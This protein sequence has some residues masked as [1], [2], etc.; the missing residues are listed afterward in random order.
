M[1]RSTCP[2]S[3]QPLRKQPSA[4]SRRSA[5]SQSRRS[6]SRSGKRRATY[7]GALALLA[8]CS[9][10]ARD[11]AAQSVIKQ[12]G[13]HPA[14][15]FEA[16]PH[17]AVG[18]TRERGLGPGFRGTFELVDNGF[19]RSINNTVGVS[20]GADVLF[21]DAILLPVA[22]QWNFWILREISVFGEVGPA[23]VIDDDDDD[24]DLVTV[25]LQ[26]GARFHFT[27][28]TTFTVRIGAPVFT[29]GASFLL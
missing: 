14:Y 3:A 17:L 5:S 22:M 25:V 21:D 9:L 27:Q 28:Y 29:F 18:V 15:R 11:A 19:I 4:N 26:G 23:I 12:P 10:G 24:H 20:F 1:R 2:P 13:V 16:E 8:A 6:S 7:G